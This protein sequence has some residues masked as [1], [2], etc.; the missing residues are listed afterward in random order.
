MESKQFQG[1]LV[2]A[3]SKTGQVVAIFSRFN[4]IDSDRDVTLPGAFEDGAEVR[5]SAYNHGSSY[6]QQ[7]PVG[8]GTLSQDEDCATAT[9]QFFM[10]TVAG[11]EHFT[12]VKEMGAL[13][14]WSYNYDIL[15][16]SSG[17]W[18]V[19]DNATQQVQIL[20]KLKVHEVSPVLRGAGIGTRTV[21]AKSVVELS[22]EWT[23][24]DWAKV[25]EQTADRYKESG[26]PLPD[27]L[28]DLVRAFDID[29]STK[30]RSDELLGAIAAI[31]NIDIP[32]ERE[33][34]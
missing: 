16:S 20:K 14:E 8:K 22:G 4:V 25:I 32:K 19:A 10:S 18:P 3:D 2:K 27:C 9:M 7:L 11:K 28:A 1:E 24:E 31:H 13:Q 33:T 15:E 26:D 17:I 23:E 29:M 5:V 30:K 12:V 21:S 34:V 6:G